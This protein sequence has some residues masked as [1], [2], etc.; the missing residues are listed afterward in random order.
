VKKKVLFVCLA[1]ALMVAPAVMLA[2]PVAAIPPN[3]SVDIKPGSCPNAVNVVGKGV[4]PVAIVGTED[5]DVTQIDLTSVE[6]EG[7][8]PLRWA[9]EDVATPFEDLLCDCHEDGPDGYLD[10]IL[11]FDKQDVIAGLGS[12]VSTV[13]LTLT[14]NLLSGAPIVGEDCVLIRAREL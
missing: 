3:V 14:G 11:K 7:V 8:A 9:L 6:L 10:L 13:L 2:A 1:M 12:H 4:L 5:F